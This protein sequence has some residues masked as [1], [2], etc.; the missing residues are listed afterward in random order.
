M[1]WD[2]PLCDA[3]RHELG[4]DARAVILMIT[5]WGA[6][7]MAKASN[8]GKR[9]LVVGDEL[10]DWI[11]GPLGPAFE[12][13][14]AK[15]RKENGCVMYI[16]QDVADV[17]SRSVGRRMIANTPIKVIF[18][19][20]DRIDEY[21]KQYG[22]T[23]ADVT[24]AIES[25]NTQVPVG[26]IGANPAVE[27]QQLNVIMQGR[28]TLRTEREFENILLR[29]NP[30]GSRVLLRDVA[31]VALGAQDYG[32]KARVNGHPS[33]AVAIKLAP[34]ANALTMS[35]ANESCCGP[36]ASIVTDTRSPAPMPLSRRHAGPSMM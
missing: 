9:K 1:A 21:R 8:R 2:S 5:N 12:R 17:N 19:L 3:L 18:E 4:R 35:A 24:A 20:N 22:L 28:D 15:L 16:T 31:R 11:D 27:G 34:A 25:Q 32:T 30:D 6:R 14:A 7:H 36:S 13:Y 10:G 33:A 23:T 29:M 26:Q